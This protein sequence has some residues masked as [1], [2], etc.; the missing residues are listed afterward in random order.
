M[1][2]W[3]WARESFC[4]SQDHKVPFRQPTAS[5]PRPHS[6]P[7]AESRRAGEPRIMPCTLTKC[8]RECFPGRWKSQVRDFSQLQWL[9]ESSC[10]FNAPCPLSRP[11]SQLLP[12]I[13]TPAQPLPVL[14]TLGMSAQMC[15]HPPWPPLWVPAAPCNA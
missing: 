15:C 6:R 2:L 3:R 1:G 14:L 7:R 11:S 4:P 9:R 10:L 13:S 5:R 12:D 8:C